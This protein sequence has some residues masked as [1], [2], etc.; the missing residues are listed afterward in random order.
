MRGCLFVSLLLTALLLG[1]TFAHVLEISSKRRMDGALWTTLQQQLYRAFATVGGA[2]EIGAIL[3]NAVLT[4]LVQGRGRGLAAGALGC[5]VFAFVGVWIGL[6]LPVNRVVLRWD[7]AHVPSE[8]STYR[9]RWDRGHAIRFGL[10]LTGF[11]LLL[12][13]AVFQR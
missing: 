4:C 9:E 11:G 8:W 5:L 10:H 3:S 6:V 13:L 2:V 7:A 1:T 12:V